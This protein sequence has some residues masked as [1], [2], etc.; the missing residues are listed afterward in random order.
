M[1]TEPS[2]SNHQTSP[3]LT[4]RPGDRSDRDYAIRAAVRNA[5][6]PAQ[7][8]DPDLLRRDDALWNPADWLRFWVVEQDGQG[9][10]TS[11][12]YRASWI[13]EPD[14][15]EV[16]FLALPG[17]PEAVGRLALHTALEATLAQNP[18][19]IMSWVMSTHPEYRVWLE[20]EGFVI[21]QTQRY[22]RIDVAHFDTSPWEAERARLAGEGIVIRTLAE[23]MPE[24]PNWL[25]LVREFDG[26][27][28]PDVPVPGGLDA[29]PLEFYEKWTSDPVLFQPESRF[30]AL[31]DG[32]IVGCTSLWH[33]P[34]REGHWE[35]GL[36]GVHPEFRR[37]G[38]AIA[39]K[40]IALSW[41]KANGCAEI[42]TD[43]A[44]QNPMYQL[45]LRLG[46]VDTYELYGMVKPIA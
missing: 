27:V 15:F 21:E 1:I 34:A 5:A 9:V 8:V 33:N 4:V 14:V 26:I 40:G 17:A 35:T 37:R 38:L 16:R 46:F 42:H 2:T 43:N 28:L 44:A 29:L 22:T 25:Q 39:L 3:T 18:R 19:K 10:G 30:L 7:P 23:W 45:N 12:G 6:I 31:A 20:D 13:R 32:K 41:A 36:T 24:E 11:S